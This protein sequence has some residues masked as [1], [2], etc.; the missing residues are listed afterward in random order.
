[1]IVRRT[2]E[3]AQ[4]D[5]VISLICLQERRRQS[6]RAGEVH[7]GGRVHLRQTGLLSRHDAIRVFRRVLRGGGE[8]LAVWAVVEVEQLLLM[9]AQRAYITHTQDGIPTYIVLHLETEA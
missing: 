1:M 5:R 7:A 6:V 3:S 9:A 8:E 2:A 4:P